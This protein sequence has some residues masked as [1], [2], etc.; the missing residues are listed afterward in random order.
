[1]NTM[2][3]LAA[4]ILALTFVFLCACGSKDQVQEETTA[5]PE[6]LPAEATTADSI[7]TDD[8][9]FPNV[10]TI[11]FSHTDP[12]KA[13]AEY[14]LEKTEGE[15]CE[16]DT[17][18]DYPENEEELV[19]LISQE[20][21]NDV[22]PAIENMPSDLRGYDIIFLCF[23]AWG[24][25]LPRAVVSFIENYDMRDKIVI[26]VVYGT[27]EELNK[28]TVEINKLFAS[29]ILINGYSFT[30][31]FLSRQAELDSWLSTVLYG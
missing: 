25:T 6:T 15:I 12:V 1:M 30:G 9:A 20:L 16:I 28:S 18:K 2:K 22:R 27:E 3:K 10:M 17:L 21:A 11:Y 13:V 7:N 23:P 26:P 8:V 19:S 24:G 14:I 5:A 4:I 31:D 29:A